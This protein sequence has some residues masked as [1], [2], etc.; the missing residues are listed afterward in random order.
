MPTR[1]PGFPSSLL[2]Y[3]PLVFPSVPTRINYL[4]YIYII[5]IGRN[6][7][8]GTDHSPIGNDTDSIHIG[9]DYIF[10]YL[11]AFLRPF[12]AYSDTLQPFRQIYLHSKMLT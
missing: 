10:G 9:E 12:Y 6:L 1:A 4:L 8:D 3:C 5:Y 11:Y 7:S 2:F